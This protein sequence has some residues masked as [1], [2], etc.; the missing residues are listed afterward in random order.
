MA[1]REFDLVLWGA[2]GFTGRLVAEHLARRAPSA[3]IRWAIGGRDR[4][5]LETLREDLGRPRL[6]MVTGNGLD[7]AAMQ[8]LAH[9]TRVVCSTVGPFALYGSELVAACATAGTHYCDLTGEVPW[10]RAMIDA[11]EAAAVA[12]G[13]R[14]VHACGFDSVPSD[15]GCLFVQEAA[16]ERYDR[17]CP[18]VTLGVK[19]MRGAFSGGTVASMLNVLEQ[20]RQDPSVGQLLASPY[21]LNPKGE[22]QGPDRRDA[23]RPQFNS[24]L[25]SWTAPFIMAPINT[26]IV[27][28]SHALMG[29][30][31]G[32]R[33][34]YRE[35][36][37]TGEGFPGWSRAVAA[38]AA[39]GGFV[40]ATSVRPALAAMK[41]LF[42]PSPGQ[43]PAEEAREAGGFRMQVVGR[44]PIAEGGRVTVRVEGRRDPGYGATSRIIG[45]AAL[46][47]VEDADDP[48]V[49]GGFW[50]PASALGLRL[51]DRLAR[52]ADVTFEV[53]S[54]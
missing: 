17:A 46:C 11:H 5:K 39:L 48:S 23:T 28:R 29:W 27:R 18:V 10:I 44:H 1:D 52:H 3:R 38:S 45:E 16:M 53:T 47:L 26:R 34:R 43:G 51:A 30:P 32:K 22:R 13:A 7:P 14:I 4:A 6:P 24:D 33:F 40:A 15:I 8:A 35:S 25:D 9:R 31:W 41:W 36:M 37:M 42:L 20:A 12:S 50:T 2:T 49:G 54:D 19:R 21:G